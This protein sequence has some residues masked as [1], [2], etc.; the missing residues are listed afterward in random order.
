MKM[1]TF[2][3]LR[4]GQWFDFVGPNH[5]MNSFHKRCQKVSARRYLDEDGIMHNV[6]SISARVYNVEN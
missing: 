1:K 3:Q 6:G 5:M 4:I 2:K